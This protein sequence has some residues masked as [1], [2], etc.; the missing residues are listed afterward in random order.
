MKLEH[1]RCNAKARRSKL[2]RGSGEMEVEMEGRL[3]EMGAR[4]G[5]AKKKLPRVPRVAREKK[6]G[7]E[8]G[9]WHGVACV[10]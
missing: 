5:A 8:F 1:W 3:A 4:L 6:S 7:S 9:R 10:Q 2:A